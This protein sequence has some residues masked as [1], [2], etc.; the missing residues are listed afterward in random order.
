MVN[1]IMTYFL[2]ALL[3]GEVNVIG[4]RDSSRERMSAII[5]FLSSFVTGEEC[6]TSSQPN[7]LSFDLLGTRLHEYQDNA[8]M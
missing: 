8:T 1:W 2:F 3:T 6:D 5:Y 7:V 4:T